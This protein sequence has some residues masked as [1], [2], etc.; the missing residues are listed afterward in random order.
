MTSAINP[1]TINITYPVAGQDNNSQGFR[2]NFAAIANNLTTAENEITALQQVVVVSGDNATPPNPV[3]N[4]LLGSTL[5]NGLYQLFSGTFYSSTNVSGSVNIDL[6]VG[7]VQ[8]FTLSDNTTFNFTTTGSTTGWPSYTGKNVFSN[9]IILV[10]SDG[11]GVW[12]PTFSTTGGV[13][14]YDTAFPY[15]PNTSIQGF[16]VGG[17]SIS[18]ISMSNSGSGYTTPVTIGFT[19]G[20]PQTNA[21]TPVGTATYNIVN[22][23]FSNVSPPAGLTTSAA[24]GTSGLV[25]LTFAAQP[26]PP[27]TQGQ[28]IV[29]SGIIPSGYNGVY[30][31]TG[32]TTTT[33]TYSGT[34]TGNQTTPG[35]I[36]TGIPGNGYAVGDIVALSS[37]PSIQLSVSSLAT[38]FNGTLAANSA[39]INNVYNFTNLT[40]GMAITA[41][42]GGI[43][44]NTIIQSI[45]AGNPGSIIM[46]GTNSTL[47]SSVAI[48]GIAGQFSCTSLSG[49]SF[50]LN[51]GSIIQVYGTLTGTGAMTGYTGTLT[52]YYIIAT[53]GSS[54]FTLSAT[55]GGSA[56]TTTAGT[57]AGLTFYSNPIFSTTTGSTLISYVSSTGPIG[58]LSGTPVGT[59]SSPLNERQS[60]LT[61]TGA[62]TGARAILSCGIGGINLSNAGNGYTT[63]SPTITISDGGG[64]GASATAILTAGTS[65]KIQVV[66]AWT[67]NAG[68]NVY[69]RYL[70]QY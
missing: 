69:I 65:S 41:N 58:S 15:I 13:V 60:L 33:V 55:L 37:N 51:T 3:V 35:T 27:F 40:V 70:G 61:V 53:D 16:V 10:K 29:V 68:R 4:N 64:T 45:S 44:A 42:S 17:E 18:G 20:S 57:T 31:V 34:T 25:T 38:N 14:S 47:L 46:G 43:P 6:S 12:A 21:V 19:G 11:N 28:T 48:T 5:S 30:T 32:C 1:S 63:L 24:S 7:A 52:N 26:S 56:I 8:Q 9:A 67:I 36:I 22:T 49:G 59:L 50:T 54:T 23:G 66:E 62:G 39:V 2:D